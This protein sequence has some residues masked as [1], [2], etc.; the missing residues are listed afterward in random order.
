MAPSVEPWRH[1]FK[2]GVC[3]M[4]AHLLSKCRRLMLESAHF[5]CSGH[6]LHMAISW[7]P[8]HMHKANKEIEDL[9]EYQE[10]P[11]VFQVEQEDQEL[12]EDQVV[13][14]HKDLRV[15][16]DIKDLLL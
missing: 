10:P 5:F 3:L 6:D 16:K 7:Y 15:H 8:G 12:L 14:D 2:S 11:R 13:Q 9:K 4:P 1:E